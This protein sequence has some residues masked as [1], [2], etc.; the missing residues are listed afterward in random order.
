MFAFFFFALPLVLIAGWVAVFFVRRPLRWLWFF[1]GTLTLLA[2]IV[3]GFS[4]APR[5]PCHESGLACMD[6][7]SFFAVGNLLFGFGTWV[8]LLI[9]TCLVEA[10]VATPR[11]RG[12][13]RV[14]TTPTSPLSSHC[15]T[16][17]GKSSRSRPG[18]ATRARPGRG[19]KSMA[20]RR[21]P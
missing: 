6:G 8:A 13:R 7:L 20:G 4:A 10:G 2:L 11:P 14:T 21:V 3:G 16:A 17:T 9:V 15:R 18:R 12:R 19:R 5:H 1:S